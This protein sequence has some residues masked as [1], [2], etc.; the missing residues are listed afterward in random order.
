M[1]KEWHGCYDDSWKG[2]IVDEAFAHPAKFAYGLIRRIVRHGLEMGYWRAGDVIGDPFGGIGTGGIVCHAHG[3]LWRGVELEPRFA[4]LADQNFARWKLPPDE[5][6]IINGDSRKFAELVGCAG[7]VTSP[8]YAETGEVRSDKQGYDDARGFEQ[9]K[10]S[11]RGALTYGFADGQLGALPEGSL[12]AVLTSPPY[13]ECVKGS[14]GERETAED[15]RDKRQTEG[16]SLGQ[17]QRHGGYGVTEGQLGALPEG[18]IA[19]VVTSPPYEDTQVVGRTS[20]DKKAWIA[21]GRPKVDLASYR[22]ID[23]AGYNQENDS[24]IGNTTGDTYW[25]AVAEIYRQCLLAMK[26]GGV[27]AVV[28]KNYVKGGKIVPLCHNTWT[29]LQ[30]V[31]FEPLERVRAMLVKEQTHDGLFEPVTKKTERKS[32]FRRLAEKKGSP[33]IDWEEVLFLRKP[34]DTDARA[35]NDT[36]HGDPNLAL[37][38]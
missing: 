12:A 23:K 7:V 1:T 27:I 14:H 6:R 20:F 9:G 4:A 21:D 30:H 8:P 16:G 10:G 17:S 13:A 22:P 24:N 33:P 18:S 31:G 2:L 25:Q 5:V 26:P 36:V 29:L 32:F 28:V 38:G 15:S 37:W 11:F 19:G 34:L 3:L 35:R